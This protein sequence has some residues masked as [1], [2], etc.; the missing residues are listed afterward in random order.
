MTS[1]ETSEYFI[2]SVPIEMPS[3]MVMVLKMTAL[4]PASLTP[5]RRLPR[6]LVDV[7]VARRHLAPRRAD[8]DLRLLE[9]LARESDRVQHGAPGG[10]RR[11]RRAPSR[12]A[13]V[14]SLATRMSQ[15]AMG[16]RGAGGGKAIEAV[17]DLSYRRYPTTCPTSRYRHR[18]SMLTRPPRRLARRRVPVQDALRGAAR[19]QGRPGDR[20]RR[21]RQAASRP[22]RRRRAASSRGP[23]AA[24]R[25]SCRARPGR[26]AHRQ[27]RR[28]SALRRPHAAADARRGRDAPPG[29]GVPAPRRSRL[30]GWIAAPARRRQAQ[31]DDLAGNPLITAGTL[32]DRPSALG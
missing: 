28:A 18:G 17:V 2:P 3:E 23:A 21:G 19:V 11:D 26:P 13:D 31:V 16:R 5:A 24:S 14:V 9:I 7:H 4:P 29:A 27:G 6:Q 1:R 10:A 8:A 15:S 25:S 30:R 22:A 12:S 20:Q 32:G